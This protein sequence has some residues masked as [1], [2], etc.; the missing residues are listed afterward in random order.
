MKRLTIPCLMLV[1]ATAASIPILASGKSIADSNDGESANT[2]IGRVNGQPIYVENVERRL[3][4]LHQGANAHQRGGFSLDQLAFQVVNDILLAQEAR[5]I[6]MDKEEPI[7]AKLEKYR[8]RLAVARLKQE[9]IWGPA[10]ASDEEV[11]AAFEELYRRVTLRVAT[12]YK[13]EDAEALLKELEGGADFATLAKKESVDPYRLRG[14][15]VESLPRADLQQAIAAAAFRAKPGELI[16]PIS[17]DIGW[18]VLRVEKFDK[19]DPERFS[20]VESD[21]RDVVRF[22]RSEALEASL[23]V[24]LRK[25]FPVMVNQVAFEAVHPERLPDGRLVARSSDEKVPVARI[26]KRSISTQRLLEALTR[27]WMGV[28]NEVAAKAATPIILEGMIQNELLTSEALARGYGDTPRVNHRVSAYETE[29]LAQRYLNE[30]VAPEVKITSEEIKAYYEQH[31]GQFLQT[32]RLHLGQ[33]SV[34]TKEEAEQVAEL[35]RKGTDLAW[36]ASQRSIDGYKE[37]GGDRGWLTP[38]VGVDEFNRELMTA[39]PGQ[40]LGPFGQ[41]E[42]FTVYRV[43]AREERGPYPLKAISGNVRTAVFRAKLMKM[44]DQTIRKLREHSEI[45]IDAQALS[46]LKI[47]GRLE[48]SG[49]TASPHGSH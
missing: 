35:L 36:L 23:S 41:K 27:R 34:A 3:D 46:K 29:L 30:V 24:K 6:G 37:R 22:R 32:P 16:G 15:L 12:A 28:H 10:E 31:K 2:A 11:R 1:L 33:V 7:P 45:Q 13:K 49:Q 39:Q 42:Q 43:I 18:A 26:G 21:L 20:K 48:Q 44:I 25:R 19:A 9:E 5:A 40:V 17:T 4:A 47:G 38:E 8:E 14:G